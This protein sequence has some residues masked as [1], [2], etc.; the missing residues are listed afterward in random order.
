MLF[1]FIDA[2]DVVYAELSGMDIQVNVG[3]LFLRLL[4]NALWYP[5][6]DGFFAGIGLIAVLEIP[7]ACWEVPI[8][9]D[10]W[11]ECWFTILIGSETV[12][13]ID[14][15]VSLIIGAVEDSKLNMIE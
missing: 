11:I 12:L 9:I 8:D 10:F 3:E 5:F 14:D 4:I 1:L 6:A 15:S 13:A 7:E 2:V